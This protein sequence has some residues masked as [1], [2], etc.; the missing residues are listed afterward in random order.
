MKKTNVAT[1][2]TVQLAAI[3]YKLVLGFRHTLTLCCQLHFS[4]Q[5]N[6]F[7]LL[8]YLVGSFISHCASVIF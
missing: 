7:A 8:M 3:Y 1:T 6:Q 2:S 5:F 4:H